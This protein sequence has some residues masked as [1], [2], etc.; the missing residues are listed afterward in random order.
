MKVLKKQ[1]RH[2]KDVTCYGTNLES[3]ILLEGTLPLF[4]LSN[5][6]ILQIP[7][8]FWKMNTNTILSKSIDNQTTWNP[9]H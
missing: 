9:L 5:I 6:H 3:L 7:I 2:N 1:G 8:D 4:N